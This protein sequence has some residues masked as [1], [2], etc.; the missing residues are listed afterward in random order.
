[1][2]FERT[3]PIDKSTKLTQ[4]MIDGDLQNY[5]EMAEYF[6]NYP[7]LFVDMITPANSTFKLFFYQRIFLRANLRY[8]YV[9]TV[10]PRAFSK[11]FVSIL[12][13]YLRCMF[14]ENE[15]FFICA[16]GKE[17]TPCSLL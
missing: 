3:M 17:R 1:M 11:S 12:A 7:D 2:K 6:I 9:Y 15:K 4:K 13:G 14:L 5:K 16:P 8:K 10:A